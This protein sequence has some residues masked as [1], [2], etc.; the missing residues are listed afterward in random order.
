[1]SEISSLRKRTAEALGGL[2]HELRSE[3]RPRDKLER[4]RVLPEL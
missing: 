3:A 2:L 4:E 1:M